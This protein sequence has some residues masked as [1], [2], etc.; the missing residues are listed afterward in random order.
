MHTHRSCGTLPMGIQDE[1]NEGAFRL[2]PRTRDHEPGTGDSEPE[3]GT[4]NQERGTRNSE[5]GA[6]AGGLWSLRSCPASRGLFIGAF[7]AFP[8]T[9]YLIQADARYR[10]PIQPLLLLAAAYGAAESF[11]LFKKNLEVK[12]SVQ[13]AP[14]RNS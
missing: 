11:K 13:P 12:A 6:L 4:R 9:Y 7:V 10:A 2:T 14:L 3:P 5:R 1:P 8:V